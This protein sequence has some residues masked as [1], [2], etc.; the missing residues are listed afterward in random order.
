MRRWRFVALLLVLWP[1]LGAQPAGSLLSKAL[2]RLLLVL[3]PGLGAQ[4]DGRAVYLP[5]VARVHFDRVVIWGTVTHIVDG[6]TFDVRLDGCVLDRVRVRPIGIDTPERG[7]CY[8]GEAT[9]RLREL[10]DGQLVALERDVN[11][12]GSF[13]RLLAYVYLVDGTWINGAMIADGQARVDIHEPDTRYIPALQRLEAQA[14]AEGVG[15]WAAC[16]W[17]SP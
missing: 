9:D 11:E 10:I 6:D 17:G 1:G 14:Q 2:T 5:M 13:G 12:W 4:A 16:A 8:Y 15:G 7:E 3:W